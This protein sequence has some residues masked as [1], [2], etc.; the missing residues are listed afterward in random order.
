MT[1]ETPRWF[2]SSHSSNGGQCLE[3]ATDLTTT[4]GVIRIR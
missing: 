2:K 1:T 3:V 4:R